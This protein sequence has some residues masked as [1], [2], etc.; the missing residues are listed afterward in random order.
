MKKYIM[1]F[2]FALAFALCGTAYAA[3]NDTGFILPADLKMIEDEAFEGTNAHI[4]V[5]PDGVLR[6]GGRAFGDIRTL[7]K[8][9]IPESTTYI[10]ESA[11]SGNACF[12]IL[13]VEGSHAE[14]WA[15][16]HGIPFVNENIWK[17]M[18]DNGKTVNIHGLEIDVLYR[19]VNPEKTIKIV[20]RTGDEEGS[21]RPQDRPELNPID[22]R[23]P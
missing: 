19:T 1:L 20:S 16:K 9:Y 5:L 15:K 10:A 17:L 11:F 7:E 13:G 6:I 2:F 23:F 8:V 14:D 12:T 4:V 18:L 3:N 22:Y 21:K